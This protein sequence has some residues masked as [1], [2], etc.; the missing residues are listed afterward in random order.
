M[1]AVTLQSRDQPRGRIASGFTAN[2]PHVTDDVAAT[3][4]PEDKHLH[5]VQSGRL[6]PPFCESDSLLPPYLKWRL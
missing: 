2:P 3:F 1:A 4:D 6:S 5:F